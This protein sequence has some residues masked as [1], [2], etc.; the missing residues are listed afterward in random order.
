MFLVR[1]I[2]DIALNLTCLEAGCTHVLALWRAIDECAH[3]LNIRIPT[4]GGAH[5]RV[6]DALAVS[7]LLAANVTN[8]GHDNLLFAERMKRAAYLTNQSQ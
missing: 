3:T 1:R 2:S 8:R 7:R 5:V 6:R 4:T